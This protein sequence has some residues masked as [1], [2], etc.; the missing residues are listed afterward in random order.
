MMNENQITFPPGFLWGAGT[1]AYQIEGAWNEDGK[2]ESIWDHFTHQPYRIK[3]NE[4]GD[5]ACDHYHRMPQ[6]VDMMKTL[7]LQCYRFSISWPRILPQ[8]KG[9]INQKGLDFY[10]RLV[11]KLSDA[12]IVPNVT[13]NHWDLPQAIQEKGGWPNRDT[14]D[15]FVDYAQIMFDR[16]G[17]RVKMWATHNEPWAISSCGYGQG[18]FAPGIAD[19][20]QHYQTAH[21]LLLSHGKT[22][23]AFRAG[24]YAGKIGIVLSTTYNRPASE[25][26]ADI[27]ACTRV[28]QD[29][30]SLFLDPIYFGTYPEL[31]MEWIGAHAP[32]IKSGDMKN[33]KQPIDFLG[34]NYYMTFDV[35]YS[36]WGGLL[37]M[38]MQQASSGNWGF[39]K[40]IGFSINPEG[41]SR[42][43]VKI[44]ETYQNPVI[45]IT[46][47][48][49]TLDETPYANG[50]V[51]DYGRID[52]IRA[53]LRVL[54]S[55][56]QDG[57]DIRGYTVWSLMDNFEWAHG[58]QPRFGIVRVDY[59]TGKR[60][61]KK[62]A[63]WYRDVI[64]NNG[65]SI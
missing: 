10:D 45:Y 65:L 1:A 14:V 40:D 56:I 60:T 41:L 34:I 32:V 37:K 30:I 19:T 59:K 27:A 29:N 44:K 33:I 38:D 6:D 21:H 54:H 64:K 2:G 57:V 5:V 36:P 28:N 63:Y 13:L 7:G 43:L 25:K 49:C 53:H 26:K 11:D 16:L 48:G 58:Y 3:N 62:S 12:G 39:T 52:Y 8:G 9:T 18:F 20:S 61:P 24:N 50:M 42:L 47:N 23:Q 17:D 4:N 15:W 35:S 22:V 46:E 51:N 55:A 31:L